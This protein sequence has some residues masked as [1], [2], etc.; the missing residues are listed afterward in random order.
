MGAWQ[1]RR[2]VT[3]KW[4]RGRRKIIIERNRKRKRRKKWRKGGKKE[5]KKLRHNRGKEKRKRNGGREMRRI[6]EEEKLSK[7]KI[8]RWKRKIKELKYIIGSFSR[9]SQTG[10][11]IM[12]V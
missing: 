12:E 4:G 6:K 8:W 9:T 3:R 10:C 1:G 7:G 5:R 2:K 11:S